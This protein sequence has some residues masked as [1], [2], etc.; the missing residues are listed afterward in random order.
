MVLVRDHDTATGY[1]LALVTTDDTAAAGPARIVS[2]YAMRWSVEQAFA[3]TRNVLGAGEARNRT[4]L[5]VERT[6]PFALL[7]H[8][9]I[10]VW[11]TRSGY[12]PAD[13]DARRDDQ[14]W[15]ADKTE[16]AFED[17]LIKLRR[18]MIA[19]RFSAP[20]PALSP[21]ATKS[22]HTIARKS[23]ARPRRQS[24]A[25][26]DRAPRWR[27][28]LFQ[29]QASAFSPP[30]SASSAAASIAARTIGA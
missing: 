13:I 16:P 25:R 17:M 30:W 10:V 15:Y 5:A 28:S 21:P 18:V 1:D 23:G 6:V 29:D 11:Y 7:T 20:G 26:R 19:A 12:D 27:Q 2:R 22:A 9:L 24:P 4:R 8:T 14:P 3:D